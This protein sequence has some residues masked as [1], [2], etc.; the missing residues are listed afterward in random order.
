MSEEKV[1]SSY[2]ESSLGFT[3]E[4]TGCKGSAPAPALEAGMLNR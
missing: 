1:K 3:Y 2:R 4:N